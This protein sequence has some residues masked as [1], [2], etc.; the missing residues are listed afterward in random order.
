MQ[1]MIE[2]INCKPMANLHPMVYDPIFK[3]VYCESLR[4][5]SGS[6]VHKE[7]LANRCT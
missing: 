3:L 1:E 6:L 2:G 5:L 7:S 4:L